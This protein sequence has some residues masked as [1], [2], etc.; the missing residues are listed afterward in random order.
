MKHRSPRI[1]IFRLDDEG[2]IV[3]HWDVRQR[4]P[5]TAA[6]SNTMF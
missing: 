2:K 4:I 6:N 1:D 3:E 5:P